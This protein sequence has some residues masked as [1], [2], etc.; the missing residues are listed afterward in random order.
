MSA[1]LETPDELRTET[2]KKTAAPIKQAVGVAETVPERPRIC[3]KIAQRHFR[4]QMKIILEDLARK[5]AFI[6]GLAGVNHSEDESEDG[7]N[8]CDW[9]QTLEGRAGLESMQVD[10]IL[11]GF[12]FDAFLRDSAPDANKPTDVSRA[13]VASVAPPT[14]F[15]MN[16]TD[17]KTKQCTREDKENAEDKPQTVPPLFET[18]KPR[19]W[20]E[21]EYQK[22]SAADPSGADGERQQA[23]YFS[24]D[25]YDL[26][27][28]LDD[29][30][31]SDEDS[32][33]NV[34]EALEEAEAERTVKALIEKYTTLTL[35]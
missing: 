4:G 11:E 30:D 33:W 14:V 22:A 31:G 27:S 5:Q 21:S 34:D 6:E 17:A 8:D 16:E 23:L 24:D 26:V 15:Q 2:G 28:R 9:T 20:P 25:S 29:S 7:S 12:D 3:K 18:E 32:K 13:P 1:P 10:G 19:P 35:E